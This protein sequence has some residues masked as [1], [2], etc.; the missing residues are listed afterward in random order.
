MICKTCNIDKIKEPVIKG[1]V[2]RFVNESG[3]VWNGK[4]CPQCY[5]V[6]NRERMRK[7]RSEKKL[8]DSLKI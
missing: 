1:E 2:T 3:Q 7:K 8:E 4:V 5:R 6:Y